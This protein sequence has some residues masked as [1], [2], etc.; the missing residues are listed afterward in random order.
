VKALLFGVLALLAAVPAAA[1]VGHEPA[2]SPYTDLDYKQELTP[3]FGYVKAREDPAHILPKSAA[4]VGLR[5]EIFLGG[6]LSFS[7][8]VTRSFSE[9]NVIDPTQIASKRSVGT[10]SA[11][12]YA[13]DAALALGLTGRKSW[14][15]IVPQLR[16]GIGLMASPAKDDSSGYAFGTSFAFNFGGGLKLVPGRRFQIRADVTERVFKQTYPDAY[17]RPAIDNT[18]VLTDPTPRKFYTHHTQLTVGV[19][20]LFAR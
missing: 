1:Q 6:P 4:M 12:V 19:S 14:H 13:A 2:E 9:R 3:L 8:D 10:Q 5:Y 18:A 7:S 15:S 20:Y 17:F 16:G 11:A